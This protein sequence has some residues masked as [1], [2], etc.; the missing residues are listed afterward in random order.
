MYDNDFKNR[1]SGRLTVK[2]AQYKAP[3]SLDN[4]QGTSYPRSPH[5]NFQ[6]VKADLGQTYRDLITLSTP[7]VFL[8]FV[9]DKL[10]KS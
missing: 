7:L 4:K 6:S 10:H 5:V 9:H 3:K 2:Y 8:S 1:K